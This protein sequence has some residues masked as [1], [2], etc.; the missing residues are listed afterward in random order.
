[1]SPTRHH[2]EQRSLR[3]IDYLEQPWGFGIDPDPSWVLPRGGDPISLEVARVQHNL[4]QRLRPLAINGTGPGA[5]AARRFGFSRQLWSRALAG[6]VWMGE[7]VMAAA[8]RAILTD[9][10]E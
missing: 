4:A 5:G 10:D 8:I 3:P 2:F 9:R 7:T 6:Q 1:V